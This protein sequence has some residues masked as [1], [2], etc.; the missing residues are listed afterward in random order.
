MSHLDLEQW[1]GSL[2]QLRA[3]KADGLL[4]T[5]HVR[6]VAGSF[7]VTERTVWRRLSSDP[8]PGGDAAPTRRG[9]APY[10]LTQTDLVAYII[11]NGNIAHL[12]RA[13]CGVLDGSLTAAGNPVPQALAEGWRGTRPVALRTLQRAFASQLSSGMRAGMTE[14]EAGRRRHEVYL[15][16]DSVPRN[17]VWEMDHARLPLMV[18]TRR[19]AATNPWLTSVLD[20][21]TRAVL[22][23]CLATRP[24]AST[25][26][27]ALAMALTHDPARGP[28]GAVPRLVRVDQGLEFAAES[29]QAALGS[30]SV[31]RDRLPGYEP[32]L[33]GKIERF[34]RT[35]QDAFSKG[36]PGFTDGP[37][38]KAGNLLGPLK[39][40]PKS[41]AAAQQA[42][43]KPMSLEEF[44]RRF[45]KWAHWYNTKK[46]HSMLNGA[47]PLQAWEA[48]PFELYRIPADTIRHLLMAVKSEH[49]IGKNGINFNSRTYHHRKLSGRAGERVTLRHMPNDP[50][51]VEVYLN[52]VHWCT[53]HPKDELTEEE[54]D[55]IFEE[56]RAKK[57]ELKRL[58]GQA[59]KIAQEE[60]MIA[61]DAPET[62]MAT[63]NSPTRPAPAP[64]PP[65]RQ[66]PAPPHK[67]PTRRQR[68][69]A[70]RLDI[71]GIVDPYTDTDTDTEPKPVD[72]SE[73]HRPDHQTT[74]SSP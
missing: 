1:R 59:R 40:D 10:E 51:F 61:G 17:Q 74:E 34:H 16:R 22:G 53:A 58:H 28:F 29:V 2:M 50:S 32:H 67:L 26:L 48:D 21:G 64:T 30:L 38:D 72:L 46:P 68:K 23:W 13:R 57:T 19:G 69:R 20:C 37:R 35:V 44:A 15:E 45:A 14:G 9:R 71:L 12:H 43:V 39:D 70:P 63:E 6:E 41:R 31:T 27:T 73:Y 66:T 60:L 8:P 7:G 65:K 24:N 3:L 52:G 25:V 47:T 56:R 5:G 54:K 49:T 4:T 11:Y 42:E 18:Q 33:K 62:Q 55:A 36:Q